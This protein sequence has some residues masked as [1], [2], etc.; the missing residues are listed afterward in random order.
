MI[1][2]AQTRSL[3]SQNVIRRR[4]FNTFWLIII[5]F[6]S[7]IN[8]SVAATSPSTGASGGV[9]F[10]DKAASN[11]SLTGIV[12]GVRWWV[13]SI[14]G[15]TNTKPLA[16]HGGSVVDSR[17]TVTL[18][19]NEYLVRVYGTYGS[20][21]G[22]IS[23]V[24]NTGRILGPYGSGDV[25]ASPHKFNITVPTG[26]EITGF[27]G[28]AKNYLHAIGVVYRPVSA[29]PTLFGSKVGTP[30][31]DKVTNTQ[32]LTG[33]ALRTNWWITSIQGLSVPKLAAHGDTGT[34]G[35]IVKWPAGEYLTRLYG[36]Y[37]A[38]IGKISFVTNKNRVLGP[39]GSGDA[40]AS[41]YA[42]NIT[43][44]DSNEI[45]GFKGYAN[46]YLNAIGAVYRK[47]TA[48]PVN[49]DAPDLAVTL[50]QPV[51]SFTATAL[52]EIPVTVANKGNKIAYPPITL[53]FPLPPHIEM[54]FKFA[55]N[56]DA[57]VCTNEDNKFKCVYSKAIKP[58][59]DTTIRMPVAPVA[60]PVTTILGTKPGP[61]VAIVAPVVGETVVANN[62]SFGMTA[63]VAV[64]ALALSKMQ[65][66]N[67]SK[68]LL[69][70]KSI[71]HYAL[72]LTNLL[73]PHYQFKPS[74]KTKDF[75]LYKMDVDVIKAH[76]LPP[77]F[78]ATPV[79]AYGTC[80]CKDD[81]SYP[82]H[83]IME[84]STLKGLNS[85]GIGKQTR[86]QFNDKRNAKS[87]HLLPVDESIHGTM[88]GEPHI[89]S[90][91]HLHGFK[92][93]DQKS[94]GFPEAWKSPTGETG[95]KFNATLTP[96]VSYNPAPFIQENNQEASVLWFH[97]HSLG[98]TRLNVYAGLA[99]LYVLRDSNEQAMIDNHS[100]PSG[101][102]EIALALQDRMFHPDGRLAYPDS[103][104]DKDFPLAPKPTMLPEFF[105]E[106]ML[107]NGVAWP[108]L[109]VEA[110]KYRFR[111][112]N[113]SNSRVYTLALSTKAK[114][115]VLGT[116]GGFLPSPVSVNSLTIAPGER[117]DIVVDFA[118]IGRHGGSVLLTN[119]A[120]IP[121]AN[122][123]G[124][125]PSPGLTDQI[126]Q[127]RIKLPTSGIPEA[128]LPKT[129]RTPLL[130]LKPQV[131]TVLR[132]VLLAEKN[133]DNPDGGDT[134]ARVEPVLG[135]V[136]D[137]VK[138][139]M[140]EV[141]ERVGAGTTEQWEIYNSTGD[142]HPIHL[143][144]GHFRIVNRQAYASDQN[145]ETLALSNIKFTKT[146]ELPRPYE[147]TWKDTVITYPQQVTRINVKF[148]NK[149]LFV[150]HCH[151][152][153]HEDHDMMR[154]LLVQ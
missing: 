100:L 62:R 2:Y 110:R 27:K 99:G 71:P 44:P 82:A 146:A 61:F 45:V 137:G 118:H 52:S 112:L 15:L 154:P 76:I 87:P 10:E 23:F 37:N 91:V 28:R 5:V 55:R 47:H 117:Y 57:W 139:W 125:A 53:T 138:S 152:L 97:D 79:Y 93:V 20:Y 56:A 127:F 147:S 67:Y 144:G 4:I 101:P 64:K 106:V 96:S 109:D 107:V 122:A 75:N 54:P 94:D 16:V 26:N 19:D 119:S 48:T 92:Q 120:K 123:E 98:I 1:L 70:P 31:L 84:H 30:F 22:T 33:V 86:I 73:A 145:P 132:Q 39:Y 142:A 12:V 129:L 58:G 6:L 103:L 74:T 81:Y 35:L 143:H 104:N 108:Y 151:I 17:T 66:E 29:R 3:S 72:P 124:E 149:G 25:G 43:V 41:P 78:P 40:V 111:I 128:V 140:D 105:G 9:A 14:Q 63:K 11:Q 59:D 141:T 83:T 50:E 114:F 89:R 18:P 36:T 113:G 135:T 32:S 13:A 77:G 102:Y 150:W 90:V 148:E 46:K 153:E 49:K 7:A 69:N 21:I 134:D 130:P 131:P 136:K 126:M 42:F 133:P 121:F 85:L 65:H 34:Q 60:E 80:D 116:E 88:A 115:M 95:N 24:T 8:G 68:P 38:H 51:P